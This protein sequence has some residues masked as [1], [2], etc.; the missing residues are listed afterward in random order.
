M[1]ARVPVRP[2][3]C[4]LSSSSRLPQLGNPNSIGAG[5]WGYPQSGRE[6]ALLLEWW[7]AGGSCSGWS[8]GIL[9]DLSLSFLLLGFWP[10]WERVQYYHLPLLT[11]EEREK[12]LI[13]YLLSLCTEVWHSHK[14]GQED[15]SGP[16][17]KASSWQSLWQSLS[18]I[19]W[20]AWLEWKEHRCS[21]L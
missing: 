18:W 6:G 5:S 12:G 11:E 8:H 9:K 7:A 15:A 1:R 4:P 13:F 14:A 16:F 3:G 20:S 10:N 21:L 2:R 17:A 19:G